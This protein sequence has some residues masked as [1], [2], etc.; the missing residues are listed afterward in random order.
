MHGNVMEWVQDRYGDSTANPVTDPIGPA[1]AAHRVF[2]GGC[3]S[4]SAWLV[5][6]AY[7]HCIG[8]SDCVG[9][10]GFRCASQDVSQEAERKASRRCL[11]EGGERS[12]P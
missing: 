10:L 6:A 1:A 8:P 2:R 3:W 4:D 9:S 7:R 12:G 5:R 11:A